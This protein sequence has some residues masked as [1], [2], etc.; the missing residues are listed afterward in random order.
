MTVKRR[1]VQYFR[2]FLHQLDDREMLGTYALALPAG[3]T[4]GCLSVTAL[5]SVIEILR[6]PVIGISAQCIDGPE[7]IGNADVHRTSRRTVLAGRTADLWNTEDLFG[8]FVNDREFLIRQR[9]EIP[10]RSDIVQHLF[11]IGHA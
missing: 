3:N 5:K 2:G 7:N 8:N 11:L 4:V 10:E 9:L 1:S 6:T